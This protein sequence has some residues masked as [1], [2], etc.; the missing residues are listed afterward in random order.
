[1]TKA[2]IAEETVIIND[3]VEP[4]PPSSHTVEVGEG[5]RKRS[6]FGK[7]MYFI[8]PA[9]ERAAKGPAQMLG[10]IK[11]ML[12]NE[13]DSPAKAMQGAEIG[14]KAVEDGYVITAKLTG[15]VIFAYYVRRMEKEQGVEH[16]ATLHAK[17]GKKMA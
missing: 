2:K 10:I 13:I 14:A 4:T 15:P 5:I 9:R 17:T 11:W 7:T 1:M 3:E 8:D 6:S 12:D 16:A